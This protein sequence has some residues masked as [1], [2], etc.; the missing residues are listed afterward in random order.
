MQ[1]IFEKNTDDFTEY[2]EQFLVE[3]AANIERMIEREVIG[4][5]IWSWSRY[6]SNEGLA[7]LTLAELLEFQLDSSY[8]QVPEALRKHPKIDF[9]PNLWRE[10]V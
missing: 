2:F 5:E 9:N 1:I 10:A 7:L 6:V 3:R 8:S 4:E